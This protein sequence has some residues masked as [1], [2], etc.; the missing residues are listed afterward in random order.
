[1]TKIRIT[2]IFNFEMAHALI[3]YDGA[4]RNIHGHSYKLYVTLLGTTIEDENN[5]KNGMVMDYK[6]LKQIVKSKIVDRFDHVLTLNDKTPLEAIQPITAI[7]P[8]F[9]LLPFQPTSEKMVAY[10][11]DIINDHLPNH[12]ELFSIRLYET[13]SCYAEWFASDQ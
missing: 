3:N 7:Y 4:C 2:K 12:V 10:F 8:N 5:T 13:E 6:D 1:M 11:A 9:E